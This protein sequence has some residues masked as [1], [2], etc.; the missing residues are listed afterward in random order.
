MDV[1]CP[2]DRLKEGSWGTRRSPLKKSGMKKYFA[3]ITGTR[4]P[5]CALPD[6]GPD[7]FP[8]FSGKSTKTKVLGFDK[9]KNTRKKIS[10]NPKWGFWPESEHAVY[11]FDARESTARRKRFVKSLFNNPNEIDKIVYFC[12][13]VKRTSSVFEYDHQ[14]ENEDLTVVTERCELIGLLRKVP[15]PPLA[16]NYQSGK[17]CWPP[18]MLFYLMT[19]ARN[20]SK[21]FKS[22]RS[23]PILHFCY[24]PAL[25]SR[26]GFWALDELKTSRRI[27]SSLDSRPF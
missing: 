23:E 16:S 20:F 9:L 26:C 15:C 24:S 12:H 11:E 5:G 19:R 22:K 13:K 18:K 21:I 4:L 17:M 10:T 1:P 7:S 6:L 27:H 8:S 2:C 25:L 3:I 14:S